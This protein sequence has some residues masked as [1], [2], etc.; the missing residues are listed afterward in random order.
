VYSNGQGEYLLT[1][2]QLYDPNTDPNLNGSWQS[3]KVR[4]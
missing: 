2:D 3:M 1:N 4:P